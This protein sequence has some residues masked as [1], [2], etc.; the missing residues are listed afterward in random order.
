LREQLGMGGPAQ[1]SLTRGHR[2]GTDRGPPTRRALNGWTPANPPSSASLLYLRSEAMREL[3]LAEEPRGHPFVTCRD[4]PRREYR[5]GAEASLQRSE[6]GA[7]CPVALQ[8]GRHPRRGFGPGHD[9]TPVPIHG[10]RSP[11]PARCYSV[12]RRL[13]IHTH[14]VDRVPHEARWHQACA[15]LGC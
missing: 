14:R 7:D 2:G 11:T 4:L 3:P 8:L 12:S 5:G 9:G 1:C 10:P 15:R 6:S 13:D